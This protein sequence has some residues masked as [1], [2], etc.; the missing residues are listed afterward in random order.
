MSIFLN[1]GSNQDFITLQTVAAGLDGTTS[2]QY[3]WTCPDVTPNAQ[4]YFYCAF[5]NQ[6]WYFTYLIVFVPKAFSNDG[7][8]VT[9]WTTRFTIADASGNVVRK[10]LL[11]FESQSA[12]AVY[13]P[14][15]CPV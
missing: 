11:I 9:T 2:D 15:G 13:H 3:S 12:E 5:T 14:S 10:G 7:A 6:F 4:I 8:P 1:T